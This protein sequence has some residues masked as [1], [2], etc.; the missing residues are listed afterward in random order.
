MKAKLLK[1]LCLCL[2]GA[3]CLLGGCAKKTAVLYTDLPQG[4]AQALVQPFVDSTGIA[5]QVLS[6]ADAPQLL[7]AAADAM[8]QDTPTADAPLPDIF[9]VSGTQA[10]ASMI[11]S[12]LLGTLAADAA[13][14]LPKG[15][16]GSGW[17]A[18]GGHAYVLVH[19]TDLVAQDETPTTF[20]DLGMQLYAQ[21]GGVVI[22]SL[23]AHYYY[24]LAFYCY[25]G[26]D[27]A[28]ITFAALLNGDARQVNSPEQAALDVARGDAAAGITTEAAARAQAQA[29]LPLAY[30]YGDQFTGMMGAYVDFYA[31]GVAAS[32][33]KTDIAQQLAAYLLSA[34][35][36]SLSVELGL[37]SVVLQSAATGAPQVKPLAIAPDEVIAQIANAER[38]LGTLL[39]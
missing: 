12:G 21:A 8:A 14:V 35:C 22:P 3:L 28:M 18:F 4:D 5:V 39:Q 6:F 15:A 24:P 11:D 20:Q 34:P 38:Q 23:D 30:T 10:C 27:L 2:V 7:R 25:N 1:A 9:L 17:G 26:P 33:S 36:E 32:E 16:R 31:V 13:I 29:G 19:N 37:S